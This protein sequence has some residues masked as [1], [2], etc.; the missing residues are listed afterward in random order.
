M[1]LSRLGALALLCFPAAASAIMTIDDIRWPQTGAYPAYPEELSAAA[2]GRRLHAYVYGGL[3]HDSNLL[4]LPS[5]F[6]TPFSKSD[7][8]S[9]LGVG[10]RGDFA[11]SR[12]HFL[13]EGQVDDNR[14]HNFSMLDNTGGRA[15]AT[16]NWEF[17]NNW[18]GSIGASRERALSGF[19][20]I[21]STTVIKDM[22]DQ[23]RAFANAAFR[24]TPDWRLR[25]G[26]AS[27]R[28]KHDGPGRSFLDSE[29]TDTILGADY[30]TP[31][32]NSIGVQYRYSRGDFP[33][34]QLVNPALTNNKYKED[35]PSVVVHYN[36]G[37]KSSIDARLGYTHRTY[38]QA[39]LP[40]FRGGTGNFAFHWTPTPKTILDLTAFRETRPF[41]S[42]STGSVL[43]AFNS[44]P[45]YV[46]AEGLTF[47][48][49]WA[50]T[51]QVVFQAMLLDE[52][53]TYQGDPTVATQREDKFRAGSV[54]VGWT[55][56][57][58]LLLS[59]SLERGKRS[60]NTGFDF[61]YN[62]VS[63]NARYTFF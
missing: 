63:A 40:D 5:G 61:D 58:P 54:S 21:V 48:P 24:V 29:Q 42:T 6:A 22:L 34:L 14:F 2:T 12:Q 26:V 11:V 36:L 44:T 19:G 37:G 62:A 59:L 35:E 47:A 51:D 32:Q 23:D 57:R 10:V 17:G 31:L 41:V 7:N 52:R 27:Y 28:Y 43:T 46:I 9:K 4:R 20:Q 30:V 16:W 15:S 33:N 38:D 39:G 56:I 50:L 1:T 18:S 53:D 55:P 49:Y 3:Y 13:L 60:S 8:F 45:T 25:G